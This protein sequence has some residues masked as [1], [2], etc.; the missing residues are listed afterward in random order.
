MLQNAYL[1]AK[2]GFDTAENGPHRF[3]KS[4][5]WD[6]ADPDGFIFQRAG[7]LFFRDWSSPVNRDGCS[8]G[9]VERILT[10]GSRA[11]LVMWQTSSKLFQNVSWTFLTIRWPPAIWSPV[12]HVKN[13][14]P[15]DILAKFGNHLGTFGKW[16][17]NI[18]FI[19]V[20]NIP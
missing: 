19:F 15:Q 4:A 10:Y 8:W 3:Q 2:I 16:F 7:F 18:H 1:L 13:R 17:F 11:L 6:T 14:K 12:N 20:F 5:E 9:S